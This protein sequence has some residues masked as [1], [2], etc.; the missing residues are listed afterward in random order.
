MEQGSHDLFRLH[1]LEI[2]NF[3]NR[4]LQI[5]IEIVLVNHVLR[6]VNIIKFQIIFTSNRINF[7][8]LLPNNIFRKI[9]V[10]VLGLVKFLSVSFVLPGISVFDFICNFNF[11]VMKVIEFVKPHVF[12]L[13]VWKHRQVNVDVSEAHFDAAFVRV[14]YFLVSLGEEFIYLDLAFSED[15][16]KIIHEESIVVTC[17]YI[18][19]E[20]VD[21]LL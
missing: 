8:D 13:F 6:V 11:L 10:P 19:E 21:E 20:E 18:Q 17:V 9:N 7:L 4:L 5:E 3:L 16:F 1:P 14:A 12:I 15:K 2:N